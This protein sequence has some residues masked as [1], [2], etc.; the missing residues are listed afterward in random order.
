MYPNWDNTPR[1]GRLGVVATGATPERFGA[2]VRRGVELAA[3]LPE[4]EQV[5]VV[6]SWNEWAEGNYLEPDG[7]TGEPVSRCW[8]SR[9]HGRRAR[10]SPSSICRTVTQ[11][12]GQPRRRGVTLVESDR[13]SVGS[14]RAPP[15]GPGASS[16]AK[17]VIRGFARLL[18][19][20]FFRQVEVE[21]GDRISLEHPTVV[22]VDHRNGLVDGLVLMG[23]LRRYPRFLGKSTLF[24]N[25]ILWP[26][27]KLAGVVPVFRAQDGGS[28]V[29]N[30]RA[31]A[32]CHRLL[33]QGGIVAIFPEGISHD[34]PTLQPLRTGA[35]RIAL[36]AAADGVSEIETVVVTLTYDD[37]QRFRS[38]AVV[39][40]G[41][42]IPVQPWVRPYLRDARETVRIVD[43]EPGGAFAERERCGSY[44]G[45]GGQVGGHR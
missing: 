17:L 25:P 6:K 30:R 19:R 26:F 1:S 5:L 2:H 9:S 27:L 28:S 10:P 16:T 45:R 38:R 15:V 4:A 7:S 8:P 13:P 3:A 40:V 20:T 44:L 39:R 37:K 43:R 36:S 42:P 32:R 11:D 35:A 21:H 14:A 22:V 23:A 29:G 41:Q 34:E 31:F 24:H 18:T 12:D 33:E